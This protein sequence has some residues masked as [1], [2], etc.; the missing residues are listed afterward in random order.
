M[1]G[2][3]ALHAAMQEVLRFDRN[4]SLVEYREYTWHAVGRKTVLEG[5]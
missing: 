1:T 5:R 4:V 2:E 3:N